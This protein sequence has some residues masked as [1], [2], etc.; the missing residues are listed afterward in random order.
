MLDKAK[1]LVGDEKFKFLLTGGFNTIFGFVI[2]SAI[3]W[4]LGRYI[5]YIGSLYVSHLISSTVAFATYR[6]YVF[7]VQG[8]MFRDFWRFQTVY[9]VPLI[10]NTFLLP[11]I[12][13]TSHINVYLAQGIATLVLTIVSY[14]GHKYFSFRRPNETREANE[15]PIDP[16][17]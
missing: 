3:Q 8:H 17:D 13:L 14:L 15:S 2:F 7:V 12:V 1:K 11:A 9:I 5:T 10:A 4:S 16:T 6:R